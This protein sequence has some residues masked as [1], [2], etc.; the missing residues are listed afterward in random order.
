[1]EFKRAKHLKA[2]IKLALFSYFSAAIID[3]KRREDT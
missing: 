3:D 1:M 2:T